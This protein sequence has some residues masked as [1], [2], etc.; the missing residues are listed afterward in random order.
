M[1]RLKVFSPAVA[2]IVWHFGTCDSEVIGSG[3]FHRIHNHLGGKR[4]CACF[5]CQVSSNC[6]RPVIAN[7]RTTDRPTSP[8]S[9]LISDKWSARRPGVH[10]SVAGLPSADVRGLRACGAVFAMAAVPLPQ[11]AAK[12]DVFHIFRPIF[13]SRRDQIKVEQ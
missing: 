13:P 7:R 10:Q 1:A 9:W 12:G 4:P 6:R 3:W 5:I 2:K 8:C 11:S